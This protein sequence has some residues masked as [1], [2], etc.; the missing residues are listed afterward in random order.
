MGSMQPVQ[1]L[2]VLVIL[3]VAAP[4]AR[5]APP[6]PAA[7]PAVVKKLRPDDKPRVILGRVEYAVLQDIHVKIKA[8]I[9]T[10]AGISSVHAK[11]LELKPTDAGERVRFQIDDGQGN[12]K[13]LWRN[14]VGWANIKVMGSDQKNRRPIV[15]LDVCIGG[16]KLEGRVNLTDRGEFLYPMLIGRNL[17][18]TGKF[19]VDPSKTYLQEPGCD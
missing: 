7:A 12:T 14:V 17:L 10:G 1:Y 8:R 16:K 5:T 9:D 13:E 4:V 2:I 6:E 18:N 3:A 15:R 11:V 19:L